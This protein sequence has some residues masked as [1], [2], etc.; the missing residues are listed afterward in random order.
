[1]ESDWLK[2]CWRFWLIHN[3][4]P[5]SPIDYVMSITEEK[6]ILLLRKSYFCADV[7][8]VIFFI[9]LFS[10]YAK[11]KCENSSYP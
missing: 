5:H 11:Q 3:H 4:H 1:M 10:V 2:K 8:C 7:C 9:V 6:Q